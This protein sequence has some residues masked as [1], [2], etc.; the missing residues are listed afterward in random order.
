MN[1]ELRLNGAALFTSRVCFFVFSPF[2][3]RVALTATTVRAAAK[4]ANPGFEG[5]TPPP[6]PRFALHSPLRPVGMAGC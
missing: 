1:A 5:E 6:S 4:N 3:F 2:S